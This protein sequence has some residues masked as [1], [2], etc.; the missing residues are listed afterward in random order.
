MITA[1]KMVVLGPALASQ[2]CRST[3]GPQSSEFHRECQAVQ[4]I[5][6]S[7]RR[8]I[9]TTQLPQVTLTLTYHAQEMEAPLN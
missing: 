1:M 3:E 4:L 8:T 5:P 7:A 6:L 2:L 9:T